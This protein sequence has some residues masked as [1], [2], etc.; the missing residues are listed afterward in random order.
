[1]NGGFVVHLSLG[2]ITGMTSGPSSIRS[3][4]IVT[5]TNRPEWDK[6]GK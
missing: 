3:G 6:A 1:M 2:K 5:G 4:H